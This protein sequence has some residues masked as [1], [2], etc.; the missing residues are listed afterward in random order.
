MITRFQATGV[1]AGT[2]NCVVRVEDPDDD[3]GQAEQDDDR[4]EDLREPDREVVVA[5][6][7]N[8]GMSSG[9]SRMK[10]AVTPPRTRRMSQKSVDATRQARARSPFSSSSLKTGTNAPESA[11]SATSARTR[12]GIWN[13]TVN[14]LIG[15]RDAE[16][17]GGDHLADEAEHAREPG[18]EP[19][20]SPSSARAAVRWALASSTAASI[21]GDRAVSQWRLLPSRAP[22]G[23][24]HFLD[25][26]NIKQQKKRVRIAGAPAAREP[27]LPLDDQDA[28]EA[29]RERPSP[30]ATPT[31][32][33]PSIAS[34]SRTIDRP[35]SRGALHKNT[36]ARK[37]SQA[38]RLVAGE[39]S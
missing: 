1:S 37:K 11:A 33:P 10:S 7:S 32:S 30:T 22:A 38:A 2:A 34:S 35:P 4:E 5:A 20:R 23:R 8:G 25:M 15:P 39:R 12:F 24:G 27:P 18:R 6:R 3:P 36:A 26:A 19:R 9:A 14:A 13:A 28:D 21:G 31:R 17:V 29:P 16:V